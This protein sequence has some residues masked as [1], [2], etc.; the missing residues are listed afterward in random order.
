[1]F[2]LTEARDY[3]RALYGS[4]SDESLILSRMPKS[5]QGTRRRVQPVTIAAPRRIAGGRPGGFGRTGATGLSATASSQE[6]RI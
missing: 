2:S 4:F 5:T 6:G 3:R 1:M